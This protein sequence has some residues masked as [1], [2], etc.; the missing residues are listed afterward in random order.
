MTTGS[1]LSAKSFRITYLQN[2][3]ENFMPRRKVEEESKVILRRSPSCCLDDTV[4][5]TWKY[6]LYRGSGRLVGCVL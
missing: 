3:L 2:R 1:K 6:K 5:K 4:A